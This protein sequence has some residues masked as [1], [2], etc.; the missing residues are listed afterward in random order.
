MSVAEELNLDLVFEVLH[1]R[2]FGSQTDTD[3]SKADTSPI[4]IMIQ[5]RPTVG[6][7]FND[8]G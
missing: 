3:S 8:I 5:Y 7:G 2:G 4:Q 1:V 6:Q